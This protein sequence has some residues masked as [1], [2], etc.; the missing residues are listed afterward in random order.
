MEASVAGAG[1][2]SDR[3]GLILGAAAAC[4]GANHLFFESLGPLLPF[5]IP[6]FGLSYTQAGRL[7]FVYYLLYGLFNYPAG[8]WAD[9]YGRKRMI[10]LFLAVS[11]GAT[12]LMA[13]SRTFWQLLLCCALAGVGGGLY[14]P[15]GTSMVSD[16]FPVERRGRALGIHGSGGSFG[17][18][19]AF[20]A[21]G[22]IAALSGW[23]TALIVLSLLGLVLMVWFRLALG[24][25]D[26]A[27]AVE[28]SKSFIVGDDEGL[29]P[30]LRALVLFFLIYGMIM[31]TFKGAYTWI[32]V[33]LKGTFGLSAKK[34]VVTCVVLPLVGI[35][36]NFLM[37]KFCDRY[38]RRLSLVLVFL[39]LCVCFLL[40]Y[41]GL[42]PILFP[43]LVLLGFLINSFAPISNA[44]TADLVPPRLRGKAFGLI[45]TFSISLSSLA[46]CIM[47]AISDRTS[48]SDSM[49]FLAAAAL[50]GA[51]VSA[52]DPGRWRW[53]APKMAAR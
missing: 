25:E 8:H 12:L 44:Y 23:R 20:V 34:A 24:T 38:G 13:F 18:F 17:T 35:F 11:S 7:G 37:G 26:P 41:A 43:L 19:L 50:L 10:F 28:E 3:E 16:A 53:L 15:P 46:P 51:A 29:L 4:H 30:L 48:L 9:R 32:P 14:H 33:Y 47:G 52:I 42:R 49:L 45:F 39:V 27:E 40:L 36:S 2:T 22:G 21:G 31:L 1:V 5:L 6:A